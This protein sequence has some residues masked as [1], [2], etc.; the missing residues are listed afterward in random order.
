MAYRPAFVG[1][2]GANRFVF[3]PLV[4]ILGACDLLLPPGE[5]PPLPDSVNNAELD[6]PASSEFYEADPA[7]KDWPVPLDLDS[8]EK[9]L[10]AT[11]R[12]GGTCFGYGCG[13]TIRVAAFNLLLN[14]PDAVE[15]FRRIERSATKAGRLFALA[16]WQLLD[17]NAYDRLASKLRDDASMIVE[18]EGGCMSTARSVRDL[19]QDIEEYSIG[20]AYRAAR[21]DAFFLYMEPRPPPVH[22]ISGKDPTYPRQALELGIGGTAHVTASLRADGTVEAVEASGE[23]WILNDAAAQS[24]TSWRFEPISGFP[25]LRVIA[26]FDFQPATPGQHWSISYRY[27]SGVAH[28]TGATHEH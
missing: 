1:P 18:E 11:T 6:E 5:P 28:S 9:L 14:Q 8:A 12:F 17:R 24:V 22:R 27:Y 21:A 23:W 26:T 4:V 20:T 7:N 2:S 25:N 16:A 15:R 10:T 3:V 19:V 13:P